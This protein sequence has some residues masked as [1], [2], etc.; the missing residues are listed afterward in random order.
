MTDIAAAAQRVRLHMTA[1][2]E[3]TATPPQIVCAGSIKTTAFTIRII[4][5]LHP[6]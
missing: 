4:P 5:Y 3:I 6:M 1:K 2:T